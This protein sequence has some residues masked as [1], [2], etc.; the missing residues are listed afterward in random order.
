MWKGDASGVL[1]NVRSDPK[2]TYTSPPIPD[3]QMLKAMGAAEVYAFCTHGVF[4]NKAW[5]KFVGGPFK[6]VWVTDSCPTQA[7]ELKGVEPFEVLSLAPLI[8]DL[9]D[10]VSSPS[11]QIPAPRCHGSA[12]CQLR[13]LLTTRERRHFYF[14]PLSRVAPSR[15]CQNSGNGGDSKETEGKSGS[16]RLMSRL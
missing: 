15:L 8:A 14:C 10:A 5:K 1:F 2:L 13:I 11:L 16:S 3:L 12:P 7:D 9:L 6:R 4:P